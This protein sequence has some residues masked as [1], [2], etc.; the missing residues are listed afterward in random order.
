MDYVVAVGFLFIWNAFLG[1][2]YIRFVIPE[3]DGSYLGRAIGF[4]LISWFILY[5]LGT[6]FKIV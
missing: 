3:R 2:V 5:A 6:V 1:V 4:G